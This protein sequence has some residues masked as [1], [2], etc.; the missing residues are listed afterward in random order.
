MDISKIET[1]ARELIIVFGD[2]PDRDGLRETPARFA[3]YWAELLEGMC[4]TNAEIAAM[5]G[6]C[7]EHISTNALVVETG[8]KVFSTCEHHLAL[9]YDLDVSIGYIPRSRVI[10][11]SKM[12]RIADMCA[13]RLQLQERIGEDISEVLRAVLD[14]DDVIVVI[15]GKHACMTARGVKQDCAVTKT[16]CLK[17]LFGSDSDLRSEFYSLIRAS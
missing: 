8:I 10:G 1:L 9:M 5:F 6:K 15:R 12:A 17:G 16:A 3:R 14:T 7:F 2:N 11:L 13:R 4:L